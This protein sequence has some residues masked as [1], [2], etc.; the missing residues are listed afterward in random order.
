MRIHI[1]DAYLQTTTLVYFANAQVCVIL[2]CYLC[3]GIAASVYF[4][5]LTGAFPRGRNDPAPPAHVSVWA[6]AYV[7]PPDAA[8]MIPGPAAQQQTSWPLTAA[9]ATRRRSAIRSS[10]R[11]RNADQVI[12][13]FQCGSTRVSEYHAGI[14][15]FRQVT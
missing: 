15:K 5:I 13:V 10:L 6:A 11:P 14:G 4:C 7:P 1:N 3:C 9:T 2:G 8:G 12:A